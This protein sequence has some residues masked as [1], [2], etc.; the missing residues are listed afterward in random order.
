[1]ALLSAIGVVLLI[2]CANVANLLLAR[3]VDRRREFA[4]RCALGASR[5]DVVGQVLTESLLLSLSAGLIG[6][7]LATWLTP[8]LVKMTPVEIPRL[9][10]IGIDFS[11]LLFTFAV[12]CLTP[13]IF[14][15][16]PA[17]EMSRLEIASTL[18]EAG[19]TGT[20]SKRQR[21][22][23]SMAVV[24]EY[25]LTVVLLVGAGLLLHSFLRLRHVDPGFQT[26]H[27]LSLAVN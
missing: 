2:G 14:G 20:Q 23:M 12:C 8:T 19:R 16:A 22:W 10:E 9:D 1:L 13:L 21:K 5:A 3:S 4:V 11:A 27:V 17:F 18:R 15:L 6:F 26:E 24:S 25:A 7:V